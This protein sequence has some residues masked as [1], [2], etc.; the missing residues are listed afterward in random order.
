M[1]IKKLQRQGEKLPTKTDLMRFAIKLAKKAINPNPN[2]RVGAVILRNGKVVGEGWHEK[3]GGPHAEVLALKQAGAKAK[4][5]ELFVTL[6]PCNHHGRTP[7]CAQTVL[8]SGIKKVFI[9]ML[10]PNPLAAGGAK[11][12]RAHGVEVTSGILKKE[13]RELNRIWLKSL[14]SRKR[15][16]QEKMPFV[17]LKLALDERGSTISK[18]GKKWISSE[19]SRREVM[20]LRRNFDAIAVGVGTIV[21][22]NPRLTI[23][24]L[25]VRQQPVRIIFDPNERTP[26]NSKVLKNSGETI[27]ITR[28]E[29]PTYDLRKIL[30][31]LFERGIRSIFLEGG[32]TT[33]QKF[34]TKNLVDEIFIFQKSSKAK[35][36]TWQ[37]KRLTKIGE[38]DDDTLFH[39]QK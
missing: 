25:K 13:C 19:K 4:G 21:A 26:K 9:G 6:E 18:P 33:A 24:G 29:F 28:Q 31:K 1:E 22:D 27:L 32:L 10:D 7:P 39:W 36:K 37:K 23:R 14:S 12:L 15:G 20:R 11:F 17:A 30:E 8:K 34:L 2:P 3:A 16:S 5:G 38:F 35:V